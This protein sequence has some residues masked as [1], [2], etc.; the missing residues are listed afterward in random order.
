MVEIRYYSHLCYTKEY[1]YC[2]KSHQYTVHAT[3]VH[4]VHIDIGKYRDIQRWYRKVHVFSQ[5]ILLLMYAQ[6][7]FITG[8]EVDS[9][10]SVLSGLL[11][12][13]YGL[14]SSKF[15]NIFQTQIDSVAERYGMTWGMK[16]MIEDEVKV[17]IWSV[18]LSVIHSVTL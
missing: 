12:L 17:I 14:G 3:V 11:N 16:N 13:R 8:R 9:C 10:H 18:L 15:V 6:F 7:T 1:I 2:T 4:I 5:G